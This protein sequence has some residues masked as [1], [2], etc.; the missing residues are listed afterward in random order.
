MLPIDH[1]R[2]AGMPAAQ[3]AFGRLGAALGRRPRLGAPLMVAET[4]VVEFAG[5]TWNVFQDPY[6]Q[7]WWQAPGEVP[8]LGEHVTRPD[9]GLT[10][11][12]RI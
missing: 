7:E 6:E 3:G 12:E 1:T 5:T 2:P 11:N 4:M 8:V 9:L 10:Q